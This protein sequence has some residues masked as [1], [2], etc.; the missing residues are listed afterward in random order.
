MKLLTSTHTLA[1]TAALEASFLPSIHSIHPSS[2]QGNGTSPSSIVPSSLSGSCYSQVIA[3]MLPVRSRLRASLANGARDTLRVKSHP[4]CLR[5]LAAARRLQPLST[6]ASL[7]ASSPYTRPS[8]ALSARS[9]LAWP[10]SLTAI[11]AGP[12]NEPI[13]PK[14]CPLTPPEGV[15]A[16]HEKLGYLY[17]DTVFPITL[18]LWDLR[19]LAISVE[20][21]TL[22]EKLRATLPQS[23]EVGY[24]FEVLGVEAR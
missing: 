13:D 22:L 23:Q 5:P 3:I 2:S 10:R 6:R 4:L 9:Q 21:K 20:S 15:L 7:L 8:I 11:A 24:G 14:E 17:F 16:P 12:A 19:R 1:A 18:G